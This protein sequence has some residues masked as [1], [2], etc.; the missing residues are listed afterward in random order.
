[1]KSKK[2]LDKLIRKYFKLKYGPKTYCVTCPYWGNPKKKIEWYH[3]LENPR[4][5]QVGHYVSRES[6]IL[7]WDLRNVHPQCSG[8]NAKH[9]FTSQY[10]YDRFMIDT[11]GEGIKEELFALQIENRVVTDKSFYTDI[12]EQL[13]GLIEEL[14]H[15]R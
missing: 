4:G 10:P 11:Y 13:L 8:C 9:K 1:M 3:P 5:L 7:R 12:A 14:E 2:D 15:E 6:T